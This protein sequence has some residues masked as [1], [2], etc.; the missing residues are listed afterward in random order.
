M[1]AGPGPDE[2][3]SDRVRLE[4]EAW[5]RSGSSP[6]VLQDEGLS[7]VSEDLF[8]LAGGANFIGTNERARREDDL[9][10][11]GTF[12]AEVGVDDGESGL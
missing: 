3:P 7:G 6:W 4:E 9:E 11:N 8:E 1:R 12:I 2:L 5:E 10:P